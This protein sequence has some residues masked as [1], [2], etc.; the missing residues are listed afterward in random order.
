V[1]VFV[2]ANSIDVEHAHRSVR[3]T[4]STAHRDDD[5]DDAADDDD[6]DDDDDAVR[7]VRAVVA[8]RRWRRAVGAR[9]AMA[10]RTTT[11]R[12]R[13]RIRW[14]PS[15]SPLGARGSG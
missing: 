1:C 8:A 2:W 3:R 12:T 14:P 6:D 7:G 11:P 9:G 4:S 15:S 13:P 10:V 5:A